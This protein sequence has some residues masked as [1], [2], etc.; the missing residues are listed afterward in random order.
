MS[1]PRRHIVADYRAEYGAWYNARRRCHN[2]KSKNFADYG[3]RG[4]SMCARW[5]NDFDA[6]MD[7]MGPR[8]EGTTLE[9]RNNSRGYEPGN[10]VWATPAVQM[11]NTRRTVPGC[12][13]DFADR[14]GLNYSTVVN[15]W[16]ARQ[17]IWHPA[18][19]YRKAA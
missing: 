2:S 9:R 3:G 17:E 10:C 11:R 4:I 15:R 14:H 5:I 18:R 16:R 12:L 1:L 8:P 19:P 7:D 13:K 6:F